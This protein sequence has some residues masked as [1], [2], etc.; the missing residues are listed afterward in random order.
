[1]KPFQTSRVKLDD[2]SFIEKNPRRHTEI[3]IRE[4]KRSVEKFGQIRPL[5]VD[6]KNV[7]LAGNG[8]LAALRELGWSEADAYIVKGLSEKDK[9]R[10]ALA[11][12]KVA[13]L[14]LDNY[15]VIEELIK[16]I[17]DDLDIPGFDD[18]ILSELLASQAQITETA[19][20]YGIVDTSFKESAEKQNERIEEANLMASTTQ[21]D[22]TPAR[23]CETCGQRVWQ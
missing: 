10:L 11:D 1:M 8:L 20:S 12:N 3:Q 9:K 15:Q 19:K 23:F 14:G 2:L 17:G 4:L 21:V 22:T 7:V 18:S 6:E 16:E 13:N 5:V